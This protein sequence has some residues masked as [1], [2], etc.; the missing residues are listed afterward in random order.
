MKYMI[1]T[2]FDKTNA[3]TYAFLIRRILWLYTILDAANTVAYTDPIPE[4]NKRAIGY[5]Y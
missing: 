5:T 2:D 3:I 1:Y 4:N